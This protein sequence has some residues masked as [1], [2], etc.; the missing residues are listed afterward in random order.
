M[1][2]NRKNDSTKWYHSILLVLVLLANRRP[3]VYLHEIMKSICSIAVKIARDCSLNKRWKYLESSTF[4]WHK[5]N[6]IVSVEFHASAESPTVNKDGYQCCMDPNNCTNASNVFFA[7]QFSANWISNRSTAIWRISLRMITCGL[8]LSQ[9]HQMEWII[10]RIDIWE[11]WVKCWCLWVKWRH[12]LRIST[13]HIS[14]VKLQFIRFVGFSCL[15]NSFNCS[16]WLTNQ[17]TSAIF[18]W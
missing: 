1:M 5:R 8:I 3:F 13:H 4:L 18:S 9:F 11:V 16:S 7:C 6:G 12:Y 17:R 10:A 14:W 2:W 15:I